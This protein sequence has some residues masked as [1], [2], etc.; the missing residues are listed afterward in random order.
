[1]T[2]ERITETSTP[3]GNTHTHTTVIT[4]Q[5]SSGGGMKW[6]GLL[7]LIIVGAIAVLVFSQM[8]DAEVAKDTA[9]SEAATKVG[10]AAGQVGDAAEEAVDKVTE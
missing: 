1:M 9:V 4:D 6:F 2:E 5:P 3:E 8:S 7:A 10:E